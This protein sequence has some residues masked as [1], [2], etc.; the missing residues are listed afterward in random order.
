MLKVIVIG[1][2][3]AGKSIFSQK[4]SNITHL[5]LYHIDMLY[6]KEDGTHI[7]KEELEENFKSIFKNDEWIIDGNYQKTLEMRIKE[8]DTVFLLDY[9]VDIC[10]EGAK[11]R[12]GKKRDD[13]P[14]VEEKLDEKFEQGIINFSNE[15]LPKIYKLLDKY[16]SNRNIIVFK[17]RDESDKYLLNIKEN[18][19]IYNLQDKMEYLDE[20]ANL[21]YEEWAKNKEDNKDARIERKKQKICNM[22]LDNSFCKLILV[23]NNKLIGFISIFPED[24]DEEKNL[25]PWYA[26]MYVKKEY[27]GQ[28]YSKI[29]N[30]AILDE[31]KSRNFKTLFLKTELENY[32]EKFG[33]I[34]IKNLKSGEKLYKFEL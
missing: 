13:L 8:C 33:A 31:A 22:F 18:I 2:P 27:R 9:P 20:I 15:K 25:T 1:S 21:E 23:K 17:S 32:Y 30:K 28:G 29:L 3:G 12:I 7:T 34:F 4:L 19:Q 11:S 5:P 24:C 10:L 26:T 16:K 6:H 14:W